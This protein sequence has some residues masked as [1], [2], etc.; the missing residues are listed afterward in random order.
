MAN[1]VASRAAPTGA[2]KGSPAVG[3]AVRHRR[4]QTNGIG[5]HVAEAGSGPLVVL[6][7]GFPELWYSW[8]HQLPVLAAAGYRVVTPDQ[9]GYGRSS[10]PDQVEDYD[11]V[12]LAGDLLGLL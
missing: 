2:P 5:M 10:R 8:R 6:C 1:Q 3:E 4:L 9:R 11:I 12:H 7:H